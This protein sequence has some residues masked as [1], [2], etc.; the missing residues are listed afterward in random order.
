MSIISL[1]DFFHVMEQIMTCFPVRDGY[2]LSPLPES[3]LRL[4]ENESLYLKNQ[5]SGTSAFGVE[6]FDVLKSD[7]LPGNGKR[8][9]RKKDKNAKEKMTSAD[10]ASSNRRGNLS[11]KPDVEIPVV[12]ALVSD[13][14]CAPMRSNSL[15]AHEKSER[16][17]QEETGKAAGRIREPKK[18]FSKDKAC[19]PYLSDDEALEVVASSDARKYGE[20]GDDFV[21]PNGKL[22]SKTHS[23]DRTGEEDRLNNQKV[24]QC[25]P[26]IKGTGSSGKNCVAINSLDDKLK[27]VNDGIAD[28]SA[29]DKLIPLQQSGLNEEGEMNFKESGTKRKSKEC[30]IN[31]V[32]H[33][34]NPKDSIEALSSAEKKKRTQSKGDHPLEKQNAVKS[35][36]ELS[37][38][39]RKEL[40]KDSLSE[41]KAAKMGCRADST[42]SPFREKMKANEKDYSGFSE[43][44]NEG[45]ST[46][47]VECPPKSEAHENDSE[48][49]PLMANGPT[50]SAAAAPFSHVVIEDNW[51][52]CDKCQKWR[53]LPYGTDP[54]QL[55][56]KWLCTMLNW[57]YVLLIFH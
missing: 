52:C 43:K 34:E 47:K 2:V 45:Q 57:L 55:P 42:E 14:S 49:V 31:D 13:V 35:I 25:G 15:V 18:A 33:T 23:T 4:M 30:E 37:K 51:V 24:V 27:G 22:T 41:S 17:I 11:T 40:H 9:F 32:R 28:P 56:K 21:H 10:L 38:S 7:N 19:L 1:D 6:G 36:K 53:L 12:H 26:Y 29:P 54:A 16:L 5:K 48:I 20:V 3:M 8:S 50:S 44:S 46:K 39:V